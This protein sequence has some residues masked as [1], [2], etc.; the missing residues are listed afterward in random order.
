MSGLPPPLAVNDMNTMAVSRVP[1]LLWLVG[2]AGAVVSCPNTTEDGVQCRD[3]IPGKYCMSWKVLE[4]EGVIEFSMAWEGQGARSPWMAVGVSPAGGMRGADILAVH[5]ALDGEW[6]VSDMFGVD[7]EPPVLDE[8]QHVT[9]VKAAVTGTV[10]TAT[11]Q[12]P[13]DSCEFHDNAVVKGFAHPVI[14]AVGEGTDLTG[15]GAKHLERGTMRLVLWEDAK[16]PVPVAN[17][18]GL[19]EVKLEMPRVVVPAAPPNS[20]MCMTFDLGQLTGKDFDT[21]EYHMVEFAP[22]LQ[23]A[24]GL[25]H[26]MLLMTC[27]PGTPMYP[28]VKTVC[29]DM[30]M[31]CSEVATIW[32]MGGS[33]VTLPDEA[34]L[35]IGKT[36]GK[37]M[38][39]QV[40]YYNPK[41]IAGKVD[42]SG[43]TLKIT[44]VL[45]K[46]HAGIIAFGPAIPPEYPPIPP[47]KTSH[48]V[49]S[50]CAECMATHFDADEV[51]VVAGM[52]H[53]HFLASKITTH[54]I[55]DGKNIGPAYEL[56]RYDYNHQLFVQSSITKL[57]RGDVLETTCEYNSMTRENPTHFGEGSQEE[58]CFSFLLYYPR[59]PRLGWCYDFDWRNGS[60]G[61]QYAPQCEACRNDPTWS[62]SFVQQQA[63]ERGCDDEAKRGALAATGN[64]PPCAANGTCKT[65]DYIAYWR[66]TE[67]FCPYFCSL[68]NPH[69]STPYV[70]AKALIDR[71]KSYTAGK[72]IGSLTSPPQECSPKAAVRTVADNCKVHTDC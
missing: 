32:A 2:V 29:P 36:K 41:G 34:G 46:E 22:L 57:R 64:C 49:R 11:V 9:L 5:R 67:T 59:Q 61:A 56:K 58:M 14:W 65:A 63:T 44:P 47:G 55:R 31:L 19:F 39:L 13:L 35:Q 16:R 38:W 71:H 21:T 51:T 62:A 30:D 3:L 27:V 50:T 12:R 25:V 4:G 48:V 6:T 28:E 43:I 42:T 37:Q 10:V 54:V 7:Y 68:G 15:W 70:C 40:H 33:P 52:A 20:Y 72:K 23:G 1:L 8:R 18:S 53:A 45:R 26:H 60:W 17:D 66:P 69:D 24:P